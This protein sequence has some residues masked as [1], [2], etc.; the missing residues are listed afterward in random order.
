MNMSNKTI[1]TLLT[2]SICVNIFCLGFIASQEFKHK[3]HK[4]PFQHSFVGKEFRGGP[5]KPHGKPH[6]MRDAQRGGPKGEFR[7]IMSE[8]FAA[9]REK[10][11]TLRKEIAT[12]ITAQEV[13]FGKVEAL[14]GEIK[15][16]ENGIR[17]KMEKR[18]LE[19]LGKMSQEERQ[20]FVKK[21]QERK[22]TL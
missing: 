9:D 15:T 11:V 14:L 12:I 2:I 17:E 20:G 22:A 19:R 3:R 13:D 5:G 6:G 16:V 7:K 8:E 4:A 1:T 18:F 21:I 10:V